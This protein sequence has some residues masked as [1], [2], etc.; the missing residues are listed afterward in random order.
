MIERLFDPILAPFRWL[1]DTVFQIKQAPTR[2]QGEINR[3][4][5]QVSMVESDFKGYKQDLQSVKDLPG[6]V[7]QQQSGGGGNQSAAQFSG[8]AGAAAQT[9]G[10]MPGQMPGLKPG[11]KWK[12]GLFGGKKC[13]SCGKGLHKS[14]EECPYCGYGKAGG[15]PAGGAA[16]GGPSAAAGSPGGSP[17]AAGPAAPAASGGKQRTMAL[18]LNAAAPVG[19]SMIGWFIPLEGKLSGDLYQL[20]GRVTVGTSPDNDIPLTEYASIS[21]HHC[22]FVGSPSGFKLNDLGSTNGTFVNDKRISTHDLVDN[23][24]V[25]LGKINFKF[26][27]LY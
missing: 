12:M 18:D 7:K 19:D 14:W 20:K 1:R 10:Q 3:A 24:N 26:K 13:P 4:K 17:M 6:G 22:E 9:Q 27:S 23:D 5:N 25:R 8:G 2:V 15:A 16:A 21:G 11:K